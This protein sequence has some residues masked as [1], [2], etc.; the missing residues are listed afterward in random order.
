MLLEEIKLVQKNSTK[1]SSAIPSI[2]RIFKTSLWWHVL[3]YPLLYLDRMVENSYKYIGLW[4]VE[5]IFSLNNIFYNGS[6][7]YLLVA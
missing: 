4:N 2:S 1:S 6:G 3:F 5:I 7:E